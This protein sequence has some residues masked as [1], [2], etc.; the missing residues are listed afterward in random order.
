MTTSPSSPSP[1]SEPAPHTAPGASPSA[2]YAAPPAAHPHGAPH[3]VYAAGPALQYA[4]PAYGGAP[5]GAPANRAAARSAPN[6]LG[7]VA[8]G[9]GVL[10]LV[11]GTVSLVVQTGIMRSGDYM[12]MSAILGVFSFFQGVLAVAAIACGAIGLALKGRSKG[13]AGIGLGI[14][15]AALWSILGGVV[16]GAVLQLIG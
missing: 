16:Y 12:A 9:L 4:A 6:V 8:L 3:G 15:V 11:S 10:V 7:I 13:A 5:Y 14:G 2:P 1:S